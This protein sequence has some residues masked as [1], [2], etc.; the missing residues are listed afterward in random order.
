MQFYLFLQR[1]EFRVQTEVPVYNQAH[2]R[3]TN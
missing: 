3:M 1:F 2:L